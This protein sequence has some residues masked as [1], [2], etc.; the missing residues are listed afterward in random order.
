MPYANT[1]YLWLEKDVE[2]LQKK[3]EKQPEVEKITF[4]ENE[5]KELVSPLI[6]N[7]IM[8]CLNPHSEKNV[9]LETKINEL[10]Q[11]VDSFVNNNINNNSTLPVWVPITISVLSTSLFFILI[12]LFSFLFK[13]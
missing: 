11:L 2:K 13:S 3:I 9:Q 7:E 4:N 6:K 5:F 12:I 8:T 1:K 10:K